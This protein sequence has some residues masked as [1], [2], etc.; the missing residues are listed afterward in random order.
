MGPLLTFTGNGIY[1]PRADVYL[2]PWQP[3]N[4]AIVT[5]GHSDHASSGHNYYLCTEETASIIAYRLSLGSHQIQVIPYGQTVNINGV[6][7]SL[8]PAGHIP[9]SAQVRVEYKGEVW[10]FTGDYKLA[11]DGISTPF[12]LVRCH[13]FITESTFGLPV[14]KWKPQSEVFAEINAWWKRNQE[15]GKTS[16]IAGY[17]LGKSQRILANIDTSI[18]PVFTHGAG[19]SMNTR[20]PA[21]GLALPEA[22]REPD[23]T[24]KNALRQALVI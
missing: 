22:P 1:C 15:E 21:S 20:M 14:Y 2:D 18:G 9:G 10:V 4:R 8:H 23:D 16:I 3:V 7:F 24:P 11:P 6:A 17:T 5:H 13:V 19:D 12:E